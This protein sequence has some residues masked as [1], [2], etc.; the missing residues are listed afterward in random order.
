[1]RRC[2]IRLLTIA[3]ATMATQEPS[4]TPVYRTGT[5]AVTVDVGVSRR[6]AP[7]VGLTASDFELLDNG[8]RQSVIL[9]QPDTVPVDVSLVF[10]HTYFA[11]ARI[12]GKFHTDLLTIAGLLR[13]IDRL[14]VISFSAD[15]REILPM[16]ET[17]GWTTDGLPDVSPS[18]A[19][20]S[21]R[22]AGRLDSSNLDFM[23]DPALRRWSLFDA[24]VLALAR[25]A[26]M[27][28]RHVVI[29]F[30]VGMDTASVMN[31]GGMLEL[32]AARAD[33]LLHVGLWN[34]R[35]MGQTRE[36]VVGQYAREAVTA[37]AL[38]TGGG[39]HDVANT[40][41]AFKTILEDVRRS[42]ILQ[43]TATGVSLSGWHTIVV[44]TPRFPQYT[45]RA[46]RGYLGR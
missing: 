6:N 24:L 28:R 15:V 45:V 31:D 44:R 2:T 14:R 39:V 38:A 18:S 33:G 30:C 3:I 12:G 10:D 25:P 19:A 32:I 27:G 23:Q 37:A 8:I 9:L 1:M 4:Q 22:R 17:R 42:Y 46:R 13:P 7:V 11:Q 29:V 5:Q 20:L 41:R 34:R 36:G 21:L 40:V 26:E 43:Y 35:V 16:Q